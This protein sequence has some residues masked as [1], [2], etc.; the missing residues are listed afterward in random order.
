VN[1]TTRVW[2]ELHAVKRRVLEL[3]ALEP[4]GGAATADY[5]TTAGDSALLGGLP[6]SAYGPCGQRWFDVK[7][8][9]AYGDAASH[10]LQDEYADYATALAAHPWI[11]AGIW[12]ANPE[13]DWIGWQG[14]INAAV[15]AGGG[16]VYGPAGIYIID[17]LIDCDP[18]TS[19]T[20]VP[21]TI[22]GQGYNTHLQRKAATVLS[23]LLR[24]RSTAN[25][26]VQ[27][28]G[29][30]VRDLQLDGNKAG[31]G[32]VDKV[33]RMSVADSTTP[34]KWVLARLWVHDGTETAAA[35]EGGGIA[36]LNYGGKTLQEHNNQQVIISDCYAYDNGTTNAWGIGLNS[37]RGVIIHNCQCWA[38]GSMGITAWDC[39][40]VLIDGCLC[41]DNV[42]NNINVESSQRVTIDGCQTY[43][44]DNST[45]LAGVKIF[46]SQWVTVTGCNIYQHTTGAGAGS[47]YAMHIWGQAPGIPPE[48]LGDPCAHILIEG[49]I[50]H[51][52]GSDG[53]GIRLYDA[54]GAGTYSPEDVT[55]RGNDI[56]LDQSL[57][58]NRAIY[59]D[60]CVDIEVEGNRI[61]GG[62]V[63]R[64]QDSDAV[65]R[66]N[67]ILA[68]YDQLLHVI[69][70]RDLDHVEVTDNEFVCDVG[71]ANMCNA[72][73][74]VA[75]NLN[76]LQFHDN[77]IRGRVDYVVLGAGGAVVVYP[78]AHGNHIGGLTVDTA[79]LTGTTYPPAAG[80]WPVGAT[81][82]CDFSGST[83]PSCYTWTG[84]NWV[85]GANW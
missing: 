33:L 11:D 43:G 42:Q 51:K 64:G 7:C 35:G 29:V 58:R 54:S 78:S 55:I 73:L 50:I 10:L 9:G 71:N 23:A 6:P 79:L 75:S 65:V 82:W 47:S 69:R 38:N 3:E 34:A 4:H 45:T 18:A 76:Y 12:A 1:E 8:Y 84:A 19:G 68:E 49:N 28:Q 13:M 22:C 36:L 81:I 44:Y 46:A 27:A 62:I 53:Y 17:T 70:V 40:D 41:R 61:E 60:T 32:T 63:L 59:A 2:E 52:A 30:V 80:T 31:G 20:C 25:P 15:E 37:N 85:A 74:Y 83:N 5:A 24:V 16:R 56:I 66:G 39:Q 57:L 72:A 21:I 48:Q 14:A 26:A 67:T 77:R